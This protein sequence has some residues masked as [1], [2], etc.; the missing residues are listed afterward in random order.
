MAAANAAT[1]VLY[2]TAWDDAALLERARQAHLD[3]APGRRRRHFEYDWQVVAAREPRLRA[4]TSRRTRAPRRR[5]PAV[6]HASTACSAAGRRTAVHPTQRGAARR[7][8]ARLYAPVPGETYVAGLDLAGEAFDPAR[9]G[10]D[11]TVLTIGRV[12]VRRG[13]LAQCGVEVVRHYAWTGAEHA[14]PSRRARSLLRE[15][16]RVQRVAVDA[17]GVGEPLASA[18]SRA[19]GASRVQALKL[20]PNR[21]RALATTC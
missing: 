2:G 21:S 9:E 12:Q 16:W 3:G 18:L 6:S 8:H 14:E 13:R 7:R 20:T 10:H 17:T 5:A 15:T 11:A 19:L 4:T 1:T